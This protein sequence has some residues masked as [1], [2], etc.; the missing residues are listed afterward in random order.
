MRGGGL[1]GSPYKPN[2]Q[3]LQL[4]GAAVTG[5]RSTT[6][7]ST[8]PRPPQQGQQA[9]L[10]TGAVGA[11]EP[12]TSNPASA[13]QGGQ[14]PHQE[15]QGNQQN[16][17]QINDWTQN[18]DGTWPGGPG[19]NRGLT[20]F[21]TQGYSSYRGSRLIPGSGSPG[22]PSPFAGTVG[23]R[24]SV[25]ANQ[26]G[27]TGGPGDTGSANGP[28]TAGQP[29]SAEPGDGRAS[30]GWQMGPG[31]S[32]QL[33][34][35]RSPGQPPAGG[36][37]QTDNS[38]PK[39]QQ[40]VAGWFK[41]DGRWQPSDNNASKLKPVATTQSGYSLQGMNSGSNIKG[42]LNAGGD[43]IY[44][45]RRANVVSGGSDTEDDTSPSSGGSQGT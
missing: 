21:S 4:A 36:A 25:L 2:T 45:A 24:R 1:T 42:L 20:M 33:V 44:V 22:S 3:A 37:N 16:P 11:L 17:Q 18:S 12:L 15:P 35:E 40:D 23:T 29:V 43:G 32:L 27:A 8:A 28:D 41:H 38:N 10:A 5:P 31:G 30:Y 34:T 7:T 13:S 6:T 14:F 9:H 26:P 19:N 39:H